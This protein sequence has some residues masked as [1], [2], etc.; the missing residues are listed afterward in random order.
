MRYSQVVASKCIDLE[1]IDSDQPLLLD[2][3]VPVEV[4]LMPLLHL[5][6]HILVGIV[7]IALQ[8]S[9]DFFFCVLPWLALRFVPLRDILVRLIASASCP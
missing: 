3:S 5:P 2:D 4:L 7:G 6:L 1:P 9:L 8:L